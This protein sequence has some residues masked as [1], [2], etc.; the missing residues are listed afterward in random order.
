MSNLIGGISLRPFV[1]VIFDGNS[2]CFGQGVTTSQRYANLILDDPTFNSTWL[3]V[4]KNISV[5]GQTTADMIS[6]Q[7]SVLYPNK[8]TRCFRSLVIAMEVRNDL[9]LGASDSTALSNIKTYC[10]NLKD[11]GFDVILINQPPSTGGTPVGRTQAQMEISRQWVRSQILADFPTA[12]GQSL[13]Y[14]PNTGITYADL[15][16]DIGGD[17]IMGDVANCA[18]LTYYQDGTHPTATGHS[19]MA[20]ILKRAVEYYLTLPI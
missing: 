11:N 19:E 3:S 13:V 7:L 10:Q 2:I 8:E 20:V 9:Q 1:N 16:C 18:S 17:S 15:V 4:K 12:T 5:G 6:R 14:L